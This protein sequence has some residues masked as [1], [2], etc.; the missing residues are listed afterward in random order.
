MPTDLRT[1][2]IACAL[3]LSSSV[4]GQAPADLLKTDAVLKLAERS[5]QLADS[6]AIAVPD[7]AP[8]SAP[9]REALRIARE[10]LRLRVDSGPF[11]LA[12]LNNL[13]AYQALMDAMP[14]ATALSNEADSQM[15]ELRALANKLNAHFQSLVVQMEA[16]IRSGD[17]DNLNRYAEANRLLPAPTPKR[18]LFY[19]DSITDFWRL[20]EYFPGEDY[21]NRGISGQ[22]TS[23]M[24]GRFKADVLDLK[25]AAIVILAGTNDLS[26]GTP[27]ATIA[28]NL[29]M[30][31]ELA[32]AHKIRVILASVLPVNDYNKATNPQF[33]R[34]RF[35]PP[36]LIRQL[37]DWLKNYCVTNGFTYLD[38][39]SEMLDRGAFL[40][41]E[42]ADDG[43]H[44]NAAGY[45][46]M[47]P[48]VTAA[49]AASEKP[50]PP[51]QPGRRFK[52]LLDKRQ[53]EDKVHGE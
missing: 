16:R 8:A 43:L 15:I 49:I 48:L 38:Y 18:V 46:A 25:P 39:Y 34:T 1:L 42:L 14:R 24:L 47:A 10:N 13:R 27:V 3:G 17:R 23:E 44:P 52:R 31:A 29:T 5:G 45:R 40:K 9:L 2:W 4:M 28:G 53:G 21:V 41:A 26:R 50:A 11:V 33:E 37:N 19:G 7:L 22:V 12:L 36:A 6:I 30:M 51:A 32:Q 35:R 20:N